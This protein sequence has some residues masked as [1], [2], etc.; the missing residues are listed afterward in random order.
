MAIP[1]VQDEYD[2][3]L[4]SA[5][6]KIILDSAGIGK[7][8]VVDP[9]MGA[10]VSYEDRTFWVAQNEINFGVTANSPDG[11]HTVFAMS[12]DAIDFHKDLHSDGGLLEDL[13]DSLTGG[14]SPVGDCQ[15]SDADTWFNRLMDNLEKIGITIGVA[16]FAL[17]L[18]LGIFFIWTNKK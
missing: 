7:Y 8:D 13:L 14:N 15:P 16:I 12:Q 18:M 2:T 11:F 10:W 9:V 5:D 17:V 3:V 4:K 6:A 1:K